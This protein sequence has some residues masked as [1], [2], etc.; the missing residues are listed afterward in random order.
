MKKKFI[1]LAV[2]PAFLLLGGCARFDAMF[3]SGDN[4]PPLKGTRI[5]LLQL[6]QQLE[7]SPALQQTPISL[8]AAWTNAFWPQAGGYPNHVMGQPTLGPNL[9]QAWESSIGDGGDSRDPLISQPVVANGMVFT[10]DTDGRLSAFDIKNGD[11]KW[12][13][14]TIPKGSDESGGV[15]GGI[16]YDGG[17]LYVTNGYRNLGCFDAA[18]GAEVWR[19][20]LQTPSQSAP[21]VAGGNVYVITI[22]NRLLV[23]SA[24]D[25]TAL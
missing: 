25:G 4:Q 14:S 22:D 18:T 2:L 6:Q 9:K 17:R 3:S 10:L 21:T 19:T 23:F 11:K 16:A 12:R 20:T 8:P 13:V 1:L 7:P 5:S 24:A 15:G